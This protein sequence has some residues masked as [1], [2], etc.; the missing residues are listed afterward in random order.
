MS[1]TSRIGHR[2]R[3]RVAGR[4]LAGAMVTLASVAGGCAQMAT[5]AGDGHDREA[6]SILLAERVELSSA[7]TRFV[8]LDGEP[9]ADGIELFVQPLNAFGEPVRVAGS[10]GVEL[11]AFV[12]TSGDPR[13]RPLARWNVPLS[14]RIDQTTHWNRAT[15]MYEL[16]LGLDRTTIEPK[17]RYVVQVTATDVFGSM[18]TSHLVM[19]PAR[20]DRAEPG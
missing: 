5:H 17:S 20:P 4:F 8:D 6:M 9:G 14:S 13:G 12:P 1:Q 16:I 19:E 11:L 2:D 10:L 3:A 7:F 18:Q 15:G